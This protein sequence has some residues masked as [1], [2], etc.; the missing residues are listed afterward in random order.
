VGERFLE[1]LAEAMSVIWKEIPPMWCIFCVIGGILY[2]KSAVRGNLDDKVWSTLFVGW[3]SFPGLLASLLPLVTR[4]LLRSGLGVTS[5]VRVVRFLPAAGLRHRESGS[6]AAAFHGSCSVLSDVGF[7]RIFGFMNN[8]MTRIELMLGCILAVVVALGFC[9]PMAVAEEASSSETGEDELITKSFRVPRNFLRKPVEESEVD[10]PFAPS[11]DPRHRRIRTHDLLARMGVYSTEGASAI[12][13]P[14][15]STL[16]V[17]NTVSNL[18]LTEAIVESLWEDEPKVLQVRLEWYEVSQQDALEF[19]SSAVDVSNSKAVPLDGDATVTNLNVR[20][21]LET[22]VEEGTAKFLGLTGIET[23]SG[24][25]AKVENGRPID[26]VSRYEAGKEGKDVAQWSTVFLG[27]VLECDSV[28]GA[29]DVTIDINLAFETGRGDPTIISRKIVGPGSGLE[30]EVESV[31]VVSQK[32][33]TKVTVYSGAT[34]LI[35]S[36]PAAEFEGMTT[37]VFLTVTVSLP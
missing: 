4:S 1:E 22:L 16:I 31:A 12:Y 34:R 25:R 37:L 19:E 3:R 10:D 15:T 21:K 30:R 7:D 18:E 2:E 33:A 11:P 20:K 8:G 26:F 28:L 35:G 9:S 13:N 27:T 24:Q 14:R 32:V 23:R 36:I 29:D 5:F 17:R 6:R